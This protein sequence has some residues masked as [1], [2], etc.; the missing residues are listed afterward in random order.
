MK[1]IFVVLVSGLLPCG[2]SADDTAGGHVYSIARGGKLYDK[3]FKT[4]K[5]GTPTMA[6]PSYPDQAAYK[7]KKGSDWRCKECHGWDYLGRDGAYGEGKHYTGTK[8]LQ[9]AFNINPYQLEKILKDKHHGFNEKMLSKKDV[10]DLTNFLR[11]G[12]FN[13]RRYIK[14]DTLKAN[15]RWE[16]G[17]AYYQTVCSGC[18]DL[19]GKGEDTPPLGKLSNENPWEVLHKIR[20]G[21]PGT[22]M[23][24][25]AAFDQQVSADILTYIQ[26]LPKN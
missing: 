23:P 6:N 18:H 22:E 4:N 19:D 12:T 14:P 16:S 11:E 21:Q 24:A 5:A 26:T 8:G 20:N 3:W 15:G 25:M 13:M 7:G 17:K 9:Y 1:K 2:V 10:T